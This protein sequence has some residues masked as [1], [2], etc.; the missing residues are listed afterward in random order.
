MFTLAEVFLK[1]ND[2][3]NLKKWEDGIVLKE[4]VWL[5]IQKINLIYI[6]EKKLGEGWIFRK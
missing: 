6:S 2:E 5:N 3:K 4:I 1:I